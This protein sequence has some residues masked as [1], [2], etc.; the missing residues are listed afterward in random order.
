MILEVVIFI[1][2]VAVVAFWGLRS[3]VRTVR[4][5]SCGGS[6]SDAQSKCGQCPSATKSPCP[7]DT[8]CQSGD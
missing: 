4:S 6:S 7:E 8:S 5:G 2:V 3:I 1:G